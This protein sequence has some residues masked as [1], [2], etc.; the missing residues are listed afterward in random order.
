MHWLF[1]L[2]LYAEF[3]VILWFYYQ[4]IQHK[5]LNY[6]LIYIFVVISTIPNKIFIVYL[7]VSKILLL[8][9]AP[10]MRWLT[11]LAACATGSLTSWGTWL[12]AKNWHPTISRW[13][14]KQNLTWPG[15][16]PMQPCGNFATSTVIPQTDPCPVT[17]C[18]QFVH[19]W[20]PWSIALLRSWTSAM[21]TAITRSLCKSGPS[22]WSWKR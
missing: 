17:N 2:D 5:N 11:S 10:K 13:N 15:G 18:F 3:W 6:F 20:C 21:Q 22:V 1:L 8:R 14:A 9:N 7:N 4:K 16:G 19:H 12:T